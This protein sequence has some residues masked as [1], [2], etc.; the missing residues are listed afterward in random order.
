[1]P[2]QLEQ[3][4]AKDRYLQSWSLG[5]HESNGRTPPLDSPPTKLSDLKAFLKNLHVLPGWFH[6]PSAQQ[7]W[8]LGLR[9]G[10]WHRNCWK[11]LALKKFI[12][13]LDI[14]PSTMLPNDC[15]RTGNVAIMCWGP[16]R[17]TSRM[18]RTQ[19]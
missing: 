14:L 18:P 17:P 15:P 19:M 11:T 5:L 1:M 10:W 3:G 4:W 6:T 2:G 7:P 12:Y 16:C 9:S 8:N 13:K